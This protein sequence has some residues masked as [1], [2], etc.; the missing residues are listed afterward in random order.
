MTAEMNPFTSFAIEV[1]M[2]DGLFGESRYC[3]LDY[4]QPITEP[5]TGLRIKKIDKA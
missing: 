1:D 3:D 2:P 5:I 4:S